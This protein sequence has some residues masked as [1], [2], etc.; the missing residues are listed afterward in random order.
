MVPNLN[1]KAQMDGMMD[2]LDDLFKQFIQV[3]QNTKS[4]YRGDLLSLENSYFCQ[5]LAFWGGQ[6]KFSS[7]F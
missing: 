6:Y 5:K 1:N 2:K 7:Y 4:I 3:S